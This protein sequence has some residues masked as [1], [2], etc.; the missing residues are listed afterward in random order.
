MTIS[1]RVLVRLPDINIAL[2]EEYL[3]SATDRIK[4][5]LGVAELPTELNSIAVEVICAMY[6]RKNHEGI[7]DETVDTFRVSFIDDILKGYEQDIARYLEMKEKQDNV[8][9]GVLRFL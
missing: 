4:L 7:K 9:R 6:N 1:Q 5:R 2:L 3:T 8:S